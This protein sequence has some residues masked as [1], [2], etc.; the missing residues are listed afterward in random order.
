MAIKKIIEG[1]WRAKHD[2]RGNPYYV[3]ATPTIQWQYGVTA[4]SSDSGI[5]GR[6]L[7]I[8]TLDYDEAQKAFANAQGIERFQEVELLR[9]PTNPWETME[10]FT[11]EDWS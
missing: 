4:K 3:A 1:N 10:I 7:L 8:T 9:R 5:P 2:Q 11:R 6:T